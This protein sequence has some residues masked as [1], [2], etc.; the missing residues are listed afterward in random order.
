MHAFV[1]RWLASEPDDD[2][3]NMRARVDRIVEHLR[4]YYLDFDDCVL[5]SAHQYLSA[6]AFLSWYWAPVARHAV[7][8]PSCESLYFAS[9]TIESDAGPIDI[10]AHAGLEAALAILDRPAIG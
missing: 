4:D 1:G 5:W 2:W 8:A 6:P 7:R 3:S 9:T 10:G